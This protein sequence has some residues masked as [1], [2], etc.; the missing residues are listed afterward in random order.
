MEFRDKLKTVQFAGKPSEQGQMEKRLTK[1]REAYKR[2]RRN[3]LQPRAMTGAAKL[4]KHASTKLEIQ[5]G[6]LFRTPE[7]MAK[8][9]E[10]MQRANDMGIGIVTD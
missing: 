3:G 10:G 8:A 6:H 1:D 7:E 4:E 5:M 9:R 2:L